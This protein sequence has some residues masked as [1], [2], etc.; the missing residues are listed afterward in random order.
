MKTSILVAVA[1]AMAL[2]ATAAC[3]PAPTPVPT[4]APSTPVPQP[5][6]TTAQPT[7][8]PQPIATTAQPTTPPQP[9]ATA[10]QPTETTAPQTA[11]AP[12]SAPAT[13]TSAPPSSTTTTAPAAAPGL[14]A[15]GMR[16]DPAQPAHGQS[17]SFSVSFLNTASGDQN[18]KWVV[19]I[20]RADNPT[21]SNTQTTVVQTTFPPGATDIQAPSGTI[22]FG[23]TGNACDYYFARVD[24]IDINNKG[25]DMTGPDGKVF[26]KPF[27]VCQ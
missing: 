1:L 17:I 23:S 15:T 16:L 11:S 7:T 9:A 22:K 12:T 8:L 5:T 3:S 6:A 19:L 21:R 24:Q 20:Y 26:E 2:L 25:T 13:A 18:V 10:A 27:T 4:L 14:Y